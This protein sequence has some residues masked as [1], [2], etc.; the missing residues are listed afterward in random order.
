MSLLEKYR[1]FGIAKEEAVR[2]EIEEKAD[3]EYLSGRMGAYVSL[4]IQC[5]NEL[6]DEETQRIVSLRKGWKK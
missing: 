2:A 1:K 6:G 3:S 5:M 4:L